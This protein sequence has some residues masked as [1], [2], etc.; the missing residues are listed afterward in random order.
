MSKTKGAFAER[1]IRSIIFLPLQGR[2]CLHVHSQVSAVFQKIEFQKKILIYLKPKDFKNFDFLSILHS[3]LQKEYRKPKL[4]IGD[5]VC[6]SKY[7]LS[8]RKNFQSQFTQEVFE[9]VAIATR[10]TF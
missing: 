3:Q 4:K 10:T 5:R 2:L 9:V 8:S 6:F 7:A 1:T